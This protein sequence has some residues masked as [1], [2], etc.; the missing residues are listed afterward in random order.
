MAYPSQIAISWRPLRWHFVSYPRLSR[1]RQALG[2]IGRQ[3]QPRVESSS[4]AAVT[5]TRRASG[6]GCARRTA[7]AHRARRFRLAPPFLRLP[8]EPVAMRS[9]AANKSAPPTP[10]THVSLD[11]RRSSSLRAIRQQAPTAPTQRAVDERFPDAAGGFS[12]DLRFLVDRASCCGRPGAQ[13]RVPGWR[14]GPCRSER[15]PGCRLAVGCRASVC[16]GC[17]PARR[18]A[19]HR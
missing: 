16:S 13:R 2:W 3:A 1:L 12:I 18:R 7:R 11:Q 19:V 9:P 15:A 5:N 17:A 6:S 8:S 10:G 4:A 14:S